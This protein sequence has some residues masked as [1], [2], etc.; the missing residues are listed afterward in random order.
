MSH[1]KKYSGNDKK[2]YNKL[3][4]GNYHEYYNSH[5]YHRIVAFSVRRGWRLL[6][7]QTTVGAVSQILTLY[8]GGGDEG[9]F[10]VIT[11]FKKSIVHGANIPT[12]EITV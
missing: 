12:P 7:E 10:G 2:N 9:G 5:H 11:R 6:V 4:G 3:K 8:I 1:R